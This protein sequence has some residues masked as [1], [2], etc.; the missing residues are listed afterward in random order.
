MHEGSD[1]SGTHI[2]KINNFPFLIRMHFLFYEAQTRIDVSLS[3]QITELNKEKNKI[4]T[5]IL[6]LEARGIHIFKVGPTSI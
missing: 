5:L 3:C 6:Y 2:H 1:H 4:L